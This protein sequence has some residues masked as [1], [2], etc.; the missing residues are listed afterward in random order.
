MQCGIN[1]IGATVRFVHRW[2]TIRQFD[3]NRTHLVIYI[4]GSERDGQTQYYM[5]VLRILFF[6]E[7][8]LNTRSRK[9]VDKCKS[10]ETEFESK[11]I[12][13]ISGI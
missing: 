13:N 7:T 3:R 6:L 12:F 4:N 5:D 10:G 8:Q 2:I 11:N 1:R 9:A